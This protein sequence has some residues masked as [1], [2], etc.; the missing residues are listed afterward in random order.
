MKP[1]Y[2]YKQVEKLMRST[3]DLSVADFNGLADMTASATEV[4]VL[5]GIPATL[6]AAEIGKLDGVT[7]TTAELNYTDVAT[8]GTGEASKAMVL[9]ATSAI[10]GWK[11]KVVAAPAGAVLTAAHTQS[12][13]NNT[14]AGAAGSWD[15][16]AATVGMEFYFYVTAAQELRINPDG[17]E[18]IGLPSTGVQQ[19]AGKY[20]VADAAGE[21]VHILCVTAGQWETLDY[22]GT[23]TAEA[24]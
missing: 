10:G 16:P 5:D 19:A 12:V 23:W 4:N 20:I 2:P 21:Y 22:R 1:K 8:A 9:D 13:Y 7:A 6:T 15:L 17:T 18:T 24:G 14:G 11:R 3:T